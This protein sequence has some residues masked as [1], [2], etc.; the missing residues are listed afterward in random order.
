[1]DGH[2]LA[3]AGRARGGL[4]QLRAA[5]QRYQADA[6]LS[7]GPERL[8]TM[9]YDRLLLDIER[10]ESAQLAADWPTA[11]A[12][13]QHAQA[14]VAELTASLTDEW[15]GSAGLRAVYTY[16]TTTL[17][18]ANIGRD[19]ELTRQCRDLVAPLGEAWHEA[20]RVVSDSRAL[21]GSPERAHG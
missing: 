2:S 16:L 9:L 5:Q 3:P 6:V 7:A 21:A 17:I 10:A 4:A 13:L 18:R 8:L 19:P 14:I 20:A 11:S 1:M 15:D 12:Q